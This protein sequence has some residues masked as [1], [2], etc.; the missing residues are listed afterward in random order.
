MPRP[1]AA[2]PKRASSFTRPVAERPFTQQRQQ[3]QEKT[4]R[5]QRRLPRAPIAAPPIIHNPTPRQVQAA[6]TQIVQSVRRAVGP[7]RGAEGQA[8]QQQLY[9]QIRTDPKYADVR[10]SVAHWQREDAKLRAPQRSGPARPGPQPRRARIGVGPVVASV[11]LTAASQGIKN[12]A[13]KAAPGLAASASTPEGKFFRAGLSDTAHLP[14]MGPQ[15]AYEVAAAA[16]EAAG[17]D[18]ERAKA[19]AKGFTQ[20]V[21]GFA[22]QGKWDELEDYVREHPVYAMLELRGGKGLV[23]RGA[24][25]AMRS[26]ALGGTAR[27]AASTK[28]AD[29]DLAGGTGSRVAD[30]QHYSPDVITKAFQVFAERRRGG[31]G[32][33]VLRDHRLR[34]RADFESD[35]AAAT[36]RALRQDEA[37][38]ARAARPMVGRGGQR[39]VTGSRAVNAVTAPV[40]AAMD[41]KAR[42]SPLADVVPNVVQGIVRPGHVVADLR[43]ELARLDRVHAAGEFSTAAQRK[44]NRATAGAIR[45][46]LDSPVAMRNLDEL[47][48]SGRENVAAVNRLEQRAADLG[49]I[50][51]ERAERAKLFPA[52]QAHLGAEYSDAPFRAARGR[53]V[54][55]GRALRSAQTQQRRARVTY[56]RANARAQRNL[57]EKRRQYLRRDETYTKLEREHGQ[58]KV[59]KETLRAATREAEATGKP[60]TVRLGGDEVKLSPGEARSMLDAASSAQRSAGSA[61]AARARVLHEKPLTHT[62]SRGPRE[63]QRVL[64]SKATVKRAE[65]QVLAARAARDKPA[66]QTVPRARAEFDAARRERQA[67]Q[68]G[69]IRSLNV[70]G[71]RLS[72]EQVRQ[73]VGADVA[74]L[75]HHTKARGARAYYQTAFAGR[76]NLDAS[77]KRTGAAFEKGAD[78][79]SYQ[80]LVEHRVRTRGVVSRIAEHDQIV[81][82]IAIKGP[83]GRMMTWEQAEKIAENASERGA[84]LVPYRAVPGSY[85]RAR[86]ERIAERQGAADMPELARMI[87]SEFAERLKE[88]APGDRTARNVVLIPEQIANQLKA[89]QQVSSGLGRAGNIASDVFR[90]TVLPFSA[91]WLMGNT[92]EAIVRL[93]AVGAGPNSYRIGRNL[94]KEIEKLDREQAIRVRAALTGGLLYGNRGLTVK[95][96]AEHF[97]GTAFQTPARAVSVAGQLPVVKQLGQAAKHFTDGVFAFNRWIESTS[98]IAALG[99]HAKREMQ[100]MT[101]SWAKATR[102]QVKALQD[103]ARGYTQS[104]N[105]HDA[106]RY[107]DETLGQYSR[108]SPQMRRFIQSTAPFLPWYLNSA[109]WVFWTLPAKHPIKT[110][111]MANVAANLQADFDAS[112]QTLPPGDLRGEIVTDDGTV[113][114]YGRYTPFGAFG[115]VLGGGDEQL[116]ALVDPL[117]PQFKSAALAGLGLNFSGHRANLAPGDRSPDGGV[118][119]A[120]RAS[121][122]F[123]SLLEAFVPGVSRLRQ[124]REGG[125][126]PFDNSTV[127]SPKVKPGTRVQGGA[128]RRILDPL[129]PVSGVKG[130]M[131]PVPAASPPSPDE[132]DAALDAA[133][134]AL[135][136]GDLDDEITRALDVIP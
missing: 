63:G 15:L 5:A 79:R 96:V 133:A 50:T 7:A 28:R 40:R 24:G 2:K 87:E 25:A 109:R 112:H 32:R 18:T 114:P 95:R 53:E 21:Y 12:L 48:R 118:G 128:A 54:A 100:E 91:K 124:V 89:Q 68:V 102:A 22:A 86:L 84:K 6:K 92:V 27:R 132:I 82:S 75:P 123:N 83:G 64:T 106:A 71:Q 76:K 26:G 117:F 85:D 1:P 104:K 31:A 46:V 90:R 129:R 108:F 36:S 66:L 134:T 56:A 59:R 61:L 130:A 101:G 136:T 107:I 115:S 30:R 10:R 105:V 97:E 16:K 37:I 3:A 70:G 120:V 93:G 111:L 35:T 126:T 43:K 55:A 65:R 125:S 98:Q 99:K 77:K 122:A 14:I 135:D 88:P 19:L 121:M 113:L 23:G 73:A 67:A 17:G 116:W 119:I 81:H 41:A 94:L 39:I 45:R 110:G 80:A 13:E 57:A 60:V 72:N 62:V 33:T 49:A 103:I 29:V 47:V 127:W 8:R 69:G 38:Q 52:A 4:D 51:P 34:R 42:R 78:D 58:L 131:Q 44:Q 11:N 74:Y 20:G 9:R